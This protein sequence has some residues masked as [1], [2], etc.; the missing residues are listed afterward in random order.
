[1]IS[2]CYCYEWSLFIGP[3]SNT[4]KCDMYNDRAYEYL[5]T[6]CCHTISFVIKDI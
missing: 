3:W 5:L 6:P 2:L 4:K 1:M